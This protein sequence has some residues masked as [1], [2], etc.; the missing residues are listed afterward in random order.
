MHLFSSQQTQQGHK[1]CF[2]CPVSVAAVEIVEI[3]NPITKLDI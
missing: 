1:L 3:Q 2:I